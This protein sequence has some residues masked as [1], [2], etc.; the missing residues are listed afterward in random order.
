VGVLVANNAVGEVVDED[1]GYVARARVADDAPRYPTDGSS[2]PGGRTPEASE[3][4][5][6]DPAT[7]VAGR[8]AADPAD[9]DAA[10]P[11]DRGAADPADRDAAD[12]ADRDAADPADG[13]ATN[14]VVG[15][16]VTNARLSKRDAVRVADLGHSG[17]ARAVRPAHTEADGDALFCLATGEVDAGV[18]LVAHLAADA[19]AEAIRR[20]TRAAVGDGEL[21]GL[22]D[23]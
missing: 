3:V 2:R 8:G 4:P 16:I 10:D 19:V 20:G 7:E 18:D 5:G 23:R 14:T 15:V 17:V 11:A 9:R 1:G 21:P 22:A 13:P 12:P 6:G